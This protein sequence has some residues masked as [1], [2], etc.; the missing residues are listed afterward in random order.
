LSSSE[1]TDFDI[2]KRNFSIIAGLGVLLP[3]LS[4][5]VN[6]APPLIAA[7][8]GF[9]TV[10]LPAVA[11][12]FIYL[13]LATKS[14]VSL[15]SIFVIAIVSIVLILFY[16]S[17]Y[18]LCTFKTPEGNVIQTGFEAVGYQPRIQSLIKELG[19]QSSQDLLLRYDHHPAHIWEPKE[20]FF[21]GFLLGLSFYGAFILWC[22]A[23]SFAANLHLLKPLDKTTL[24]AP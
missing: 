11:G 6:L 17:L 7:T 1:E 10:F 19:H 3:A 22:V 9:G 2:Q 16:I 21:A 14:T 12:L 8:L 23:F 20:L 4:Y 13:I 24:V 18:N 15:R 5:F